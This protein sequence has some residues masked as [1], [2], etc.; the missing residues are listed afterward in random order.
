MRLDPRYLALGTCG[1]TAFLDMYATQPLLPS[2]RASFGVGEAAVGA[3]ISAL[4]F[5]C[6]LAAP[7]V[8]PLAD[9]IG[10]KR[11]IVG[12]I[13]LLA[14]VTLAAA[15]AHSLQTLIAW[16][17]VQGLCMPAVFAVSLA[18]I[19]EEFP[20]QVGGRAM[21]AYITGNVL[22]GFLGRWIAALVAARWDWQ[23]SFLVLGVLNLAGGALVLLALPAARRFTAQPAT[24]DALRAMGRFVR[25]PVLLA[26]YAVGGSILFTLTATFTFATFY[27]AGPPFLLPTFALGNVF[28][29]YLLGV[30]ATPFAG[31]LVDRVGHRTT[32]LL[33]LAT[34]VA[35]IAVTLVPVL[36]AVVLG[37]GLVSTGVFGAQVASQGYIGVVARER[38]STAAALYLTVY[39]TAGGLGAI[40]PAA[41]WARGG[42]PATVALIVAVQ[43]ATA[44]V[45]LRGWRGRS[46]RVQA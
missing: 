44:I 45:A 8:G 38:R 39:Y 43:A 29:V 16:R 40:V 5:A 41:L 34:S 20:P 46:A 15:S 9:A 28:A 35:G 13:F 32:L 6:A 33:A 26:T 22:G 7:F 3:T 11:V 42:W 24:L 23:A 31:R 18:Y 30:V 37:L 1:G 25:D 27:L 12:A 4:T 17:F 10:R 2:L 14:L 19:A 21:G 36:P